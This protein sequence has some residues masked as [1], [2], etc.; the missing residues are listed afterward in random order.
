MCDYEWVDG[1]RIEV[2]AAA[3][4]MTTLTVY[5]TPNAHGDVR[6]TGQAPNGESTWMN[7]GDTGVEHNGDEPVMHAIQTTVE[8][9]GC[10]IYAQ[11]WYDSGEVEAALLEFEGVESIQPD[12]TQNEV[13]CRDTWYRNTDAE[14][15][16][17]PRMG[18]EPGSAEDTDHQD[19]LARLAPGD[20]TVCECGAKL[21]GALDRACGV[22]ASCREAEMEDVL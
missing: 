17:A 4:G 2:D 15:R 12:G 10:S 16:Y 13:L 9:E 21:L 19:R 20:E 22:C 1:P 5:A 6:L 14:R 18:D 3:Q 7:R 11:H 8:T